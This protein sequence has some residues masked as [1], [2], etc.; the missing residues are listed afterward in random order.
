M[1]RIQGLSKRYG[2]EQV[3]QDL[4]L[5]LRAGECMAV[6]GPSGSGKTTLLRMLAGEEE[7][8][9]GQMHVEGRSILGLAPERR[10]V[11]MLGQEALLFPHLDVF[12]NLAFGLRMQSDA[13]GPVAALRRWG[14]QYWRKSRK[15]W[16]RDKSYDPYLHISPEESAL[17]HRVR[18][19]LEALDLKAHAR[20]TP[21]ALSGGQRQRVAFGRALLI[22][23]KVVLLD[24]P[25]ASLDAETRREMQALYR[26]LSKAEGTTALLVTHDLREAL[27]LGDRFARLREGRLQHYPDRAAFA[28][29][30]ESGV[31]EEQAFWRDALKRE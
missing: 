5:D 27:V 1:I 8:D 9:A 20:K 2:S 14:R 19:M 13:Q 21:S 6:L 30:P 17:Q 25:F 22:R 31:A 10:G 11:V 15:G 3:L 16:M 7:P 18:Q 12:E 26:R 24:E 28:A 29:D 4:A 23:P